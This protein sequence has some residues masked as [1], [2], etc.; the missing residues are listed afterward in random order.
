MVSCKHGTLHGWHRAGG[1]GGS[2]S[3]GSGEGR[4][5]GLIR[6]ACSLAHTQSKHAH[7]LGA[8]ASTC[9]VRQSAWARAGQAEG[10]EHLLSHLRGDPE[11]G[12][13]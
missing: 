9:A 10:N 3:E 6:D 7:V 5:E 1:G 11:L 13:V 2:C 4:T 12:L 8:A